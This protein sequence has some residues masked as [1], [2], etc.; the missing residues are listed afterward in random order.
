MN[1]TPDTICALSTPN[2]VGA[3]AMIR[4][5]GADSFS[6]MHKLFKKDSEIELTPKEY[7]VLKLFCERSGRALTRE[8]ILSVVWQSSILTTQRSV[9]QCVNTLRKKIES[10][11]P[12]P[13][14]IFS[15]RDIGYRFE[16]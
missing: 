9:D 7:G 11:P 5:S 15:I 4:L 6:I 13:K 14:H 12:Q 10:N 1:Y 8:A 2:G 16:V 3:I